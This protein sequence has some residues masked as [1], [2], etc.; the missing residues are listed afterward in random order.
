MMSG[1]NSDTTIAILDDNLVIR[2]GTDSEVV[3]VSG[4][5][6]GLAVLHYYE[7]TL[8]GRE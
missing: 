1:T 8:F 2:A 4:L 7:W 6:V 5:P 3:E